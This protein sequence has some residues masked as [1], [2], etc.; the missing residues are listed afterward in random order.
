ML[1]RS[2]GQ[3]DGEGAP[4]SLS[5]TLAHPTT[6]EGLP[7]RRLV[8]P[9]CLATIA[10]GVTLSAH[11][12]PLSAAVQVR[13]V[14]TPQPT[15]WAA[16]GASTVQSGASNIRAAVQ[17]ADLDLRLGAW[18]LAASLA[19][20]YAAA[21]RPTPAQPRPTTP[22]RRPATAATGSSTGGSCGGSLP[23]CRV[24]MCESGGDPRAENPTSTAS[25]R[26]QVLDSTWMGTTAG[27]SS[28]YTHASYAPVSVQDAVAREVYAKGG[29]GQWVCK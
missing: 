14:S 13:G 29:A 24:L 6:S 2:A 4:R 17:A 22:T 10:A 25:G 20:W 11:E 8:L 16:S 5:G 23:S 21:S 1:D 27:R 9:V 26:W 18:Y 3:V 7:V 15:P 19:D 12:Q 28:G